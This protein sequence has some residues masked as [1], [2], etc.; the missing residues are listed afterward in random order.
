MRIHGKQLVNASK[1]AFVVSL[2][3]LDDLISSAFYHPGIRFKE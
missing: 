3:P 2:F 1:N